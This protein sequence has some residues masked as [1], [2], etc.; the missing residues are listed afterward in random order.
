MRIKMK[1]K[2][3]QKKLMET[4]S[5]C[6]ELQLPTIV[7]VAVDGALIKGYSIHRETYLRNPETNECLRMEGWKDVYLFPKF[8]DL[9]I[10]EKKLFTLI[11]PPLPAHWHVFD[12]WESKGRKPLYRAGIL[13]NS[14]N[15]YF[16]NHH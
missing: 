1:T 16:I 5:P 6:T 2:Q 12:F 8:W 7:K 4:P 13:R 10:H 14:D 15:L 9:E 11:F 3:R